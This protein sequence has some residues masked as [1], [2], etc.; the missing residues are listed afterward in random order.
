MSGIFIGYRREDSAAVAGRLF[1]RLRQRF[2]KDHIFRD[3]YTL[4]GGAEFTNVIRE[5]IGACNAL[6]ALIGKD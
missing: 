6:I 5:R 1:D 2:G 4:Y 3:I